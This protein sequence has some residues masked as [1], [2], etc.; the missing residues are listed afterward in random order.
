LPVFDNDG[1]RVKSGSDAEYGWRPR[2]PSS[3]DATFAARV[4][5]PRPDCLIMEAEVS[6]HGAPHQRYLSSDAFEPLGPDGSSLATRPPLRKPP[7]EL[8]PTPGAAGEATRISLC[9]ELV[10]E[11][12]GRRMEAALGEGRERALFGFLVLNRA[13]ALARDQLIDALWEDH[14]PDSPAAALSTVLSR[15]R[16]AL[17]PEIVEGRLAISMRLSADAWIDVEAAAHHARE[18]KAVLEA[19]DAPRCLG[20]AKAAADVAGQRL[21]PGLEY[22]WLEQSRRELEEVRLNAL[23]LI[24]RAGLALGAAGFEEAERAARSLIEAQPYRETG[25]SLLMEL[26]AARGNPAEA[27]LVYDLL[28]VLLREELGT[29]PGTPIVTLHER[30]LHPGSVPASRVAEAPAP[31][32]YGGDR[33][34]RRPPLP[35]ILEH[36][37]SQPFVGRRTELEHRAGSEGQEQGDRQAHRV[38]DVEA[39]SDGTL[40][41]ICMRTT[42]ELTDPLYRRLRTA[43]AER[44]LRGYSQ[45]V[46]E[47]LGEYLDAEQH[48]REVVTAIEEAEGAWSEDDVAELEGARREAWA[49]WQID[50]SSTPTS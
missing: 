42:V 20:C 27:L 39:K 11:L 13:R 8:P 2:V 17:G 49:Q 28:R 32:A 35:S 10:I 16:R 23:E 12:A 21:L 14:P 25:Y 9:G 45:I 18:A 37:S 43:A 30:L 31:P 19:G 50:P 3:R 48:R 44:G 15:L 1:G 36:A 34:E 47:A 22:K 5:Q 46:E 29:V 6:R 7:A 41:C 33:E 26:H 24:G 38:L 40:T 4:L